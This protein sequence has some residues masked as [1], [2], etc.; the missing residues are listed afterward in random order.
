MKAGAKFDSH[1]IESLDSTYAGEEKNDSAGFAGL[2]GYWQHQYNERFG[3][4]ADYNAYADFHSD[5]KENDVVEQL[6]SIEPQWF[7]GNYIFSLPLQYTYAMEDDESKY[8]RYAVAP[9]VTWKF[10]D[11]NQA[12]EF[13]G[14]VSRVKDVDPYPD[15]DEDG[16]SR[17]GGMA[18]LLFSKNRTYF[19]LIGDY[20]HIYYDS[21]AWDYLNEFTN[22]KRHDISS[23]IG[24]E[25]NIQINR[26]CDFLFSYTFVHAHSNVDIYDYDKHIVQA[27]VSVNF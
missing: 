8:H 11:I 17:G 18:Y 22:D 20:H 6:A 24:F 7:S 9:T 1:I 26:T 5:F 12:V 16:H 23:S 14:M 4:R 21:R 25:H 19:R 13:Y 15:F 27:G 10:P 2:S 3:F